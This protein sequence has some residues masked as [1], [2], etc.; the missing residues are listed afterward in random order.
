MFRAFREQLHLHIKAI[1]LEALR[2]SFQ[3]HL[4]ANRPTRRRAESRRGSLHV[5]VHVKVDAL[6]AAGFILCAQSFK[7]IQKLSEDPEFRLMHS[8]GWGQNRVR[9]R[10]RGALDMAV[11]L[12]VSTCPA[13]CA[14]WA[15]PWQ[16][17][18]I[19]DSVAGAARFVCAWGALALVADNES[20]TLK[21]VAHSCR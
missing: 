8:E 7:H 9:L 4:Q 17:C 15:F 6:C 10:L 18:G 14:F 19:L 16:A 3:Q 5:K 21:R 12:K 20:L 1:S 11:L 2:L 13:G